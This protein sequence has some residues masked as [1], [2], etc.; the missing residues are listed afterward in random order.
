MRLSGPALP[1]SAAVF[2]VFATAALAQHFP[3]PDRSP[4]NDRDH[5]TGYL[6]VTPGC[7]T[8]RLPDANCICQKMNPSEQ[9]LSRLQLKCSTR[10]AGRWVACPVKPRYGISVD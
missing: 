6:C 10:E 3:T 2:A 1:L 9:R 8:L 4:S 5:V 7:D